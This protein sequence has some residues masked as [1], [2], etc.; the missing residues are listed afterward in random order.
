QHELAAAGFEKVQEVA[1]FHGR[2]CLALGAFV[3]SKS[4]ITRRSVCRARASCSGVIPVCGCA[5]AEDDDGC[6]GD[7]ADGCTG[8]DAVFVGVDVV[9]VVAGLGGGEGNRLTNTLNSF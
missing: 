5:S 7:G 4:A 6:D 8:G 2:V 9:C 3:L 1:G